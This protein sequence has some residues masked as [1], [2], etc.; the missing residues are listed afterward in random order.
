MSE[1]STGGVGRGSGGDFSWVG[2]LIVG[3]VGFDIAIVNVGLVISNSG[4]SSVLGL[5][6]S[7][8]KSG[9]LCV[10]EELLSSVFGRC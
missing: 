5:K 2:V 10:S 3:S 7:L 6:G 9:T 8:S 1:G 4:R